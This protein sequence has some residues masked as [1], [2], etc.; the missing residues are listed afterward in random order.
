MRREGEIRRGPRGS[1]VSRRRAVTLIGAAAGLPLLSGPI[2]TGATERL[3]VFEWRGRAL[4]TDARLV[5]AHADERA[6]RRA[7]KLC[8]AEIARLEKAFSLF[9]GESEISRLN[10]D[11]ELSAPSLDMRLVL[12][13]AMRLGALS[14]GAF[15]V[16]VQPLWQLYARHFGKAG[17]AL[18]HSFEQELAAVR[19]RVD[20]RR[21]DLDNGHV[22]FAAPGMAV[23]LNGI[24][25]GYITD[26]ASDLLRDAGFDRVLVQLGETRALG[27]PGAGQAWRVAIPNPKAAEARS[28]TV[29][30]VDQAIATSSG[31]A[32]RFEPSGR[33]HHIYDPGTG[34]S[35]EAGFSVS[36]IADR[37]TEADALSTALAVTGPETARRILAESGGAEALF[38]LPDGGVRRVC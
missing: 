32:T 34:R 37:A 21:L 30:I 8:M 36:V 14:R 31:L 1:S 25:Q 4:G 17:T 16:T 26:R 2:D 22:R 19:S 11:G 10:R 29:E 12:S 3:P 5:L 35:A 9:A 33:Y 13:E 20:Y 27:R 28:A 38:V 15:D 24:A 18:T 7:A 6:A 23:T